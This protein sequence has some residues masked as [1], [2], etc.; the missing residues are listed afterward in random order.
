MKKLLNH[1][2]NYQIYSVS[3]D[4]I[5]VIWVSD[6]YDNV[7]AM[8]NTSGEYT[9]FSVLLWL[10][11]GETYYIETTLYDLDSNVPS[12]GSFWFYV[13]YSE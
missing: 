3:E 6:A 7:M 2:L 9:E 10:Q 8:D 1:I 5:P 12:T 4:V 13:E 11:E